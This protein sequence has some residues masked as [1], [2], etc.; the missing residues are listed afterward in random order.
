MYFM[1]VFREQ[2]Q[3]S[4]GT[5]VGKLEMEVKEQFYFPVAKNFDSALN[6]VWNNHH[7][8]HQLCQVLAE[9]QHTTEREPSRIVTLT[10]P[11]CLDCKC[12]DSFCYWK[13][14]NK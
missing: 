4:E 3:D 6:M 9:L 2:K 13:S 1:E 11:N 7:D 5:Q 8:P 10:T 14:T 12:K